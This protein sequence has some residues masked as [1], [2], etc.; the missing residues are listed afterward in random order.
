MENMALAPGE[1]CS[2]NRPRTTGKI[3]TIKDSFASGLTAMFT[4]CPLLLREKS[5]AFL[6]QV[7][8]CVRLMSDS[9]VVLI[10][11]D[12][13]RRMTSPFDVLQLLGFLLAGDDLLNLP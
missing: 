6:V 1:G 9:L 10:D 3:G 13:C 7:C 12:D 4:V 8:H 5:L 11:E 2:G